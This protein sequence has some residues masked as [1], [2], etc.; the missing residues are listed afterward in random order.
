MWKY[1]FLAVL[2][3]LGILVASKWQEVQASWQ[4]TKKFLR[5]VRMEMQKVSWPSKNDVYGSTIVVMVAVVALTL[6]I[7]IWD[8]ALSHVMQWVMRG[9]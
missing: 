9:A 6:I 1:F 4:A 8:W 2:V 5:E 3:L 7:S